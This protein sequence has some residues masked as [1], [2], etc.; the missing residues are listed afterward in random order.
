MQ[1]TRDAGVRVSIESP[2]EAIS[3]IAEALTT[4]ANDADLRQRLGEGGKRR[5]ATDFSSERQAAALAAIYDEVLHNTGESRGM[6]FAE[7]PAVA[8][9]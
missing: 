7:P 3:G 5:V 9:R 8:G 4:L 2:E 6:Q 1:V